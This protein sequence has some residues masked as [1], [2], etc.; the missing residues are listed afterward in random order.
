MSNINLK[1]IGSLPLAEEVNE[2]TS[3]V[4]WDGEKTVRVA[5]DMVGGGNSGGGS[6]S[7]VVTVNMH[8]DDEEGTRIITYDA[9]WEVIK[10]R[11]IEGKPTFVRWSNN[12]TTN[13]R[14]DI[15]FENVALLSQVE[16]E[17]NS[18]TSKGLIAFSITDSCNMRYVKLYSD[19][20]AVFSSLMLQRVSIPT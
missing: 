17:D 2:N 12:Y 6:D 20:T 1:T 19:G 4:G 13:S 16:F 18:Y 14:Q 7:L 15:E 8:F 10:Q 3:L 5:K 11:F 9:D